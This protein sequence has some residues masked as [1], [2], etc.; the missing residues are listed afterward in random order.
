MRPLPCVAAPMRRPDREARRGSSKGSYPSQSD[1]STDTS[2]RTGRSGR[3]EVQ[4]RDAQAGPKDA[5]ARTRSVP[6]KKN[7]A[8]FEPMGVSASTASAGSKKKK[9]PDAIAGPP[10]ISLN[11]TC[12]DAQARSAKGTIAKNPSERKK[13]HT[14]SKAAA[15]PVTQ[16]P[17]L[18]D[19]EGLPRGGSATSLPNQGPD[20]VVDFVPFRPPEFARG[21]STGS[22]LSAS[23]GWE[24]E[25]GRSS[26]SCCSEQ[27]ERA[28]A[29]RASI[30][31]LD[32]GA[33]SRAAQPRTQSKGTDGLYLFVPF[34]DHPPEPVPSSQRSCAEWAPTLYRLSSPSDVLSRPT[35]ADAV[36]T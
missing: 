2:H 14:S 25:G 9:T 18:P 33:L 35:D 20:I 12:G 17:R 36:A 13:R 16:P 10:V 21:L 5:Q 7:T 11:S 15:V 32:M 1:V 4:P 8:E 27:S 3:S 26:R 31:R 23:Q 34:Y 28:A 22:I 30:P 6:K 19:V 29:A 24:S